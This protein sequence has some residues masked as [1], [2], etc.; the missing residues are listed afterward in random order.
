MVVVVL[1]GLVLAFG[2]GL[3]TLFVGRSRRVSVVECVELR[4]GTDVSENALWGVLG[5]ISGLPTSAQV[6]LE[7]VG[8]ADGIRH[9]LHAEPGTLGILRAHLRGLLPRVRLEPVEPTA[10]SA[11]RAAVRVRWGGRHPLL[12]SDRSGESAAALLGAL[13]DLHGG[14][15][16]M[17]RWTLRP[18]R[19]PHLPERQS[20]SQARNQGFLVRL[21]SEQPID[22]SHL[23]A[24]RAKY[25]GPVLCARAVV[26]VAAGSEGRCVNLL[27]RVTAVLRAQS[28]LRGRPV[29][30]SC[31]S[32][33]VQRFVERV[34]LGKGSRFSPAELMGLV[35]WPI[36]APRVPGLVLG[37]APQLL[38]PA[39]IPRR[40]RVL[41]YSTWPG[42]EGRPLAQPL[43]GALSHMVAAGPSG[44]GKSALLAGAVAQ[45]LAAGRGC[46]VLD[47]KGDLAEEILRLVPE[48]RRDEVIVLDPA[49]PGPVPGLRVFG[50][51]DPELS[52]DLV[53]G[54]FRSIF[55]DSWGVRSDKWLRA[56][57]VTLAYDHS[58]TL[59]DL[60]FLFAS[61]SFRRRL[62]GQ[63]QDPLLKATWA[64][65]EAMSPEGRAQQLGSPLGKVNELVGR[66]VVRSVLAQAE[67]KWDMREVLRRGQVVIVSLSPGVIGSP[68][69]RLLAALVVHELFQAV[70]ARTQ[71][72]AAKRRAFYV[73]IDEPKVFTDIPMPLDSLF[74]LARGLGV[75]L[76]LSAQSISQLPGDLAQAAL[77]NA[78]TLV[79]FR[80]NADDAK[81]LARELPGVS[82]EELQALGRFEIAAR[83]GLG[84]GDVSPP[85]TGRTM[86][87]PESISDP[88][89]VRRESAARYGND[90]KEVDAALLE[91]HGLSDSDPTSGDI[92]GGEAPLRRRRRQAP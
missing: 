49:R 89:A 53:L 57:L 74:E 82:A 15:R 16:V 43:V 47:G 19:G 48:G 17:V 67:P 18:A 50:G 68:A 27:T 54:M 36:D 26:A 56:A 64:Q 72:P 73:Y 25:S 60:P 6:A 35:G 85:V 20:R 22:P 76:T 79:A 23:P 32:A 84:P 87:P 37:V 10:S 28:G 3:V 90:P 41:A 55:I 80:Q 70:Q 92:E 86:P 59:A 8:D 71:V 9:Y 13:S 91:R 1:G 52:G 42:M 45:D 34:P 2:G 65:F 7:L 63:L 30:R 81:L 61:D 12:R 38:P 24:L 11:W 14:E 21:F 39:R 46:L 4:F 83:F 66:R 69:S 75:G 78:A 29:I 33:R 88:E 58:A 40:G 77:T 5:C 31:R 62:T 51:G 44:V